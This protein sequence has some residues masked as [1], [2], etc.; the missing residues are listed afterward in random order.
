MEVIAHFEVQGW[1]V[2]AGYYPTHK[3]DMCRLTFHNDLKKAVMKS[4]CADYELY[5]P[6]TT[7]TEEEH[8]A[9]VK[10]KANDLLSTGK[11]LC[12]EPDN[13]GRESN[14]AHHTLKNITLAFYYANTSKCLHQFPEFQEYVPY[15]ALV[16]VTAMKIWYRQIAQVNLQDVE[17]GYI[18]LNE[19]ISN[20]LNH[21]H[22]GLKLNTML[23]DWAQMGMMGYITKHKPTE[24]MRNEFAPVLD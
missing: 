4:L 19:V 18:T 22:H 2:E 9:A 23:V 20:V 15:K 14:F 17:E 5:P 21:P 7:K 13:Q 6:S 24:H 3:L 16:L 1:E 12:G 10:K 8:I 11:Y